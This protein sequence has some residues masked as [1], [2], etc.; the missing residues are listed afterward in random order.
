MEESAQGK[1]IKAENCHEGAV[2]IEQTQI[3]VRITWTHST[4]KAGRF[5]CRIK[6]QS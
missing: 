6:V 1:K 3:L 2:P 5:G 4:Y